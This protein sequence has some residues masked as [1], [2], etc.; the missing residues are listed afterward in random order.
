[1]GVDDGI[2]VTD[3][4]FAGSDVLATSY[5]LSE[6]IKE[7]KPDIIVCG[8]QTTDGD[9]AQV[10]AEMS[11]FL[12]IPCVANVSDVIGVENGY[13]TVVSNLGDAMETVK[14]KLPCLISVEKE[15]Y[16]PRLPSFKRKRETGG[17]EM[18]KLTLND[19]EDKDPSHYG[20]KG[21]PTQVE[22]IFPPEVKVEKIVLD[23]EDASSGIYKILKD[24][25]FI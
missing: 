7:I 2:L 25:K 19:F 6:A 18:K 22:K 10:G 21:S 24:K 13:L 20:L 8:K 3:R 12:D 17:M 11:E 5:T 1:M 14:I 16:T 23:K 4:A 15:I 9:T